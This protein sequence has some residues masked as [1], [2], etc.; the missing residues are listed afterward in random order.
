M[1]N[2]SHFSLL[3]AY[4]RLK[5]PRHTYP[6]LD[7]VVLGYIALVLLVQ[8][9]LQISPVVSVFARVGLIS[10][11][12]WAANCWPRTFSLPSA[13]GRHPTCRCCWV[14]CCWPTWLRCGRWNTA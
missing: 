10:I 7:Q 6:V 12:T 1:S 13:A 9:L 8:V 11:Q 2:S 5:T 4:S 14:F 3:R